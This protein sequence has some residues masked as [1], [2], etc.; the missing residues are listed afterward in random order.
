M[1]AIKYSS[2]IA[3]TVSNMDVYASNIKGQVK[4]CL[5]ELP[6]FDDVYEL[7]ITTKCPIFRENDQLNICLSLFYNP[8]FDEFYKKVKNE[9]MNIP[10]KQLKYLKNNFL[11]I[12][13]GK[14]YYNIVFKNDILKSDPIRDY[15]IEK[16]IFNKSRELLVLID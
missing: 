15:F 2:N 7:F 8:Y 16:D 4:L 9:I 12:L 3:E 1:L 10:K 6:K 5:K 14:I 13:A 11:D